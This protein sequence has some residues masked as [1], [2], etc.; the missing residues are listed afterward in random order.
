[1]RIRFGRVGLPFIIAAALISA[2]PQRAASEQRATTRPKGPDM[3]A[4][5][6]VVVPPG[7]IVD[8]LRA[9]QGAHFAEAVHA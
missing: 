9:E 4:V 2:S 1:M 3:H 7:R 6:D 5:R 8:R